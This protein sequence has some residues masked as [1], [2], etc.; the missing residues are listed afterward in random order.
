MVRLSHHLRTLPIREHPRLKGFL[1]RNS[2]TPDASPLQWLSLGV[3]IP[4]I[5]PTPTTTTGHG[6]RFP[7]QSSLF[8]LRFNLNQ[9]CNLGGASPQSL[10]SSRMLDLE[11]GSAIRPSPPML[12]TPHD[13]NPSCRIH[14]LWQEYHLLQRCQRARR[15]RRGFRSLCSRRR[16]RTIHNRRPTRRRWI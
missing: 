9:H 1:L 12:S 6:P 11:S 2:N 3:S 7:A 16:S 13:R 8:T 10:F 5:E 4:R 14:Q 15:V